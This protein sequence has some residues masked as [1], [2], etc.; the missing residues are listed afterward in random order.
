[1]TEQFINLPYAVYNSPAFAALAPIDI[2]V[3]LL[4]LSKR[5]GHNNGAIA[6]GVRETAARCRCG[7]M[8]ACRALAHL[9]KQGLISVV[10]KGHLVPEPGR[11]NAVSL[12]RINFVE[13]IP[14]PSR[15][16][17]SRG[18]LNGA[19]QPRSFKNGGQ[20]KKIGER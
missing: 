14:K 3:L 16:S 8:T 11:P 15:Q 18:A 10:Y 13:D 1:M 20:T 17:N 2:A 6:L 5:N 12:W 9:Q 7:Q 4:V 19:Q